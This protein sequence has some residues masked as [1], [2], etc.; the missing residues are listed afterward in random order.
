MSVEI[1][2]DLLRGFDLRIAGEAVMLGAGAQRLLAFLALK[3][4]PQPRTHVAA[5]L[6]PDTTTEK[7]K[8]SLRTS[9]WRIQR[10]DAGIV[11]VQ[12][13][14]VRLGLDVVVDYPVVRANAL[15]LLAGPVR[16]GELLSAETRAALACELLPDWYDD[17]AL[18]E[19]EQFRQLR[20][21]AL[22]AMCE[23]LTSVGRLG[24]A[25]NAGLCAVHAEPLRESAHRAVIKSHLAAHNHCEALRQ[26]H[27]YRHLL[28]AELGLDPSP[29]LTALLAGVV[30]PDRL[31]RT[32]AVSKGSARRGRAPRGPGPP[33]T[34]LMTVTVAR[35][36][37]G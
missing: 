12:A 19:R 14:R 25:V 11:R 30:A 10:V 18:V 36:T 15:R 22:E 1:A 4:R 7:S 20:L 8:A 9:L 32:G 13:D 3:E 33:G 24:E 27:S 31:R 21:H 37:T 29:A 5:M 26:Y 17:W 34:Y 23:S 16:E 2:V 28:N 6:W 35:P